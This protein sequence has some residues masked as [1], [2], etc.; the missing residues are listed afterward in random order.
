[1]IFGVRPGS[2][3]LY[4]IPA[5]GNRPIRFAV[6]DLPAGLEV[7]PNN[8]H[9]TGKLNQLG[10]YIVTLH[11]SN[12]MG[13]TEKNLR[14]VCG[15]Q[16]ALTPPMGWSSWNCFGREVTAAGIRAEADA[17]VSSSLIKHGWTYVNI[18]D[19]WAGLR[20]RNG[21]I[22]SNDNFPDMKALCDYVHS[23]GLKIGIYS[24]PGPETC[25]G[26]KGS[27][28]HEEQ[29]A[30]QYA[31]W[32]FD[33]LK[34]DLCSYQQF[35]TNKNSIEE[36]MKPYLLMGRCL[37]DQKRDIIYSLCQY[38]FA[39]VPEW[40]AKVGGNCWRTTGDIFDQWNDGKE[41]WEHGM[42]TIG[43]S[44]NGL[45]KYASP[46]HWNDP[47][48]LV[49]GVVG[50][51]K[52]RASRLTPDEQYTHMS[53]WSLLAASL[54]IGADLTKLDA[55][56][57][58]LLEN[59]E[60]LAINQDALGKQAAC[61]IQDGSLRVFEKPLENSAH[62]IGFFNLGENTLKLNFHQ[63]AKLGLKDKATVRDLWRQKDVATLDCAKDALPLSIPGHG[64][65]LYKFTTTD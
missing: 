58:S 45:E 31:A 51:G 52:P 25:A 37:K 19:G 49:V 12:D 53:L 61:V 8:G 38:G 39:K 32:G 34:Y 5:T 47:D 48:M 64:V 18:D 54:M 1:N 26:F 43:F 15:D 11:A 57:L 65:F 29:D 55:F 60:V 22:M 33:Y 46:G 16:I 20:D 27:Y 30:R 17:I 10:T 42:A 3:L 50:W 36:N 23:K 4:T 59:D 9:I 41:Q 35:M 56:T 63:F 13:K 21:N 6:T 2:P 44:Q 28:Q 14:I 40:G 62:A 7:N 24:S